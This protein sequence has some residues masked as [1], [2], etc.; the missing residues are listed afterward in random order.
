MY[1]AIDTAITIGLSIVERIKETQ[2]E[3][4]HQAADLIARAHANQKTFYVSGSGHSHSVAEELYGRAGS[5]AFTV[6]I[7]TT[8]LT[9]TEHPTKSTMIERLPGYASIL[10]QL[11]EIEQGDVVLIVSNSGRNAYPVEL[12]IEAKKRGANV[13][14]LTNVKHSQEVTSRHSSG[15]RVFE[16]SDIIIDNCGEKGDAATYL[17]GINTP[18]FPTSSIAN[19]FICGALSVEVCALLQ[20]R[21][22]EVE[23][24]TSANVDGGFEK[25]E[26]Y[27][28]KYGRMY[29]NKKQTPMKKMN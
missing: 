17:E 28:K 3:N 20:E 21:N 6:P 19:A 9:L 26:A 10:A 7:L 24:F 12:A 2:I 13:I 15:K 4:I 8:E 16:V 25:N 1:K 23:V 29:V 14:S 5:L 11:Y 27:F 18:I 22:L